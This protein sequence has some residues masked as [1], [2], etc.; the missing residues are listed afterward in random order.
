MA[1]LPEPFSDLESYAEQWCLPTE[2]E[3]QQKRLATSIQDIT[4]FY[5]ATTPRLEEAM[6]WLDQYSLDSL[7]PEALNLMHLMFSLCTVSFA[8]EC[9]HQ[10]HIPDIGSVRLDLVSGPTP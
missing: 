3:R 2:P 9:W 5:D 10:P 8:V 6:T 4:A 7:P 1:L